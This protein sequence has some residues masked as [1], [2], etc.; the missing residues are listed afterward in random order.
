MST[1]PVNNTSA[2]IFSAINA[3]NAAGS[4]T[5]ASATSSTQDQFL[6]L[7]TTQLQ[8]QDPLNPMDNAQMTS[9]LAQISTVDGITQLNT[10]LQSLINNANST[11]GLQA[12]ALVGKSVLVPGSGMT[13]AQGQGLAGVS[14]AGPADNVVATIK[15]ANG[16]AVQTLNLGAM[17]AGTNDVSWDG[18]TDSGAVAADGNYTVSFAATQGGNTVA[19]TALQLGTVSSVANS[20]QGASLNLGNLGLFALSDVQQIF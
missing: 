14:L 9:Q 5:S 20:S 6:K 4:S 19:A 16:L 10:T 1:S 15:D 2:A 18:K 7:L 13:L 17:A 11:Q 8:N 12:A 3:S